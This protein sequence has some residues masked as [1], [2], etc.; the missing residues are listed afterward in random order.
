MKI[1]LLPVVFGSNPHPVEQCFHFYAARMD[2][3]GQSGAKFMKKHLNVS[4]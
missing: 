3:H 2:G 1:H 4:N